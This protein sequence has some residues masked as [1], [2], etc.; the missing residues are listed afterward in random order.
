MKKSENTTHQNIWTIAKARLKLRFKAANTCDRKEER[1]QRSVFL[2]ISW[3]ERGKQRAEI[4]VTDNRK[5]KKKLAFQHTPQMRPK[6]IDQLI[7][8]GMLNSLFLRRSMALFF[9]LPSRSTRLQRHDRTAVT[10]S[11][12]RGPCGDPGTRA[13]VPQ[14]WSPP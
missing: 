5:R 1:S 4:S 11:G 14:P 3:D 6:M 13:P 12:H 7:S 2:S 9:A 8:T 10:T